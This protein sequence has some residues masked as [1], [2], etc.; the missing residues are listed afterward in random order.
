MRGKNKKKKTKEA[1]LN[2]L[3]EKKEEKYPIHPRHRREGASERKGRLLSS[4]GGQGKRSSP[5]RKKKRKEGE[6]APEGGEGG[7]DLSWGGK[8]EEMSRRST[9]KADRQ[10]RETRRQLPPQ[11]L[12]KERESAVDY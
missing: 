3:F 11:I 1:I 10:E 7:E 5:V 12:H 8:K 4:D 2:S 6:R 9:N